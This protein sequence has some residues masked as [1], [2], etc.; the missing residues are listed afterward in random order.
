MKRFSFILTIVVATASPLLV[1]SNDFRVRSSRPGI[2]KP[3]R[4][5]THAS[6][7]YQGAGSSSANYSILSDAIASGGAP[8]QSANYT[9]YTSAIGEFDAGNSA[10]I[11]SAD[12]S[13]AIGYAGQLSGLEGPTTAVSRK[14]HSGAGVF[15]I[16]LPSSGPV[17]IECRTGGASGD[18]ELVVTF[19]EPVMVGSASVSSGTGTVPP[20]GVTA[21]GNQITVSLTGVA[22]AQTIFVTLSGVSDGQETTDASVAMSVLLG[23]TTADGFVNSAD[24]SQTKSQSGNAVTISN[25][26]EDVNLDGLINSGD[27]SLVKSKSGTALP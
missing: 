22:N 12:Y 21:S 26:R 15:D 7:T 23:D 17:G 10:L 24:I 4:I 1:S 25:F 18:Y 5:I 20:G 13:G 19:A 27:I 8:A 3:P 16:A 14:T 2:D 9:M 11:A 6:P